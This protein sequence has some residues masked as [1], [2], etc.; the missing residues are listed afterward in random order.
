MWVHDTGLPLITS[1]FFKIFKISSRFLKLHISGFF[2]SLKL[3]LI[4]ETLLN[5]IKTL[6]R[7]YKITLNVFLNKDIL[8]LWQKKIFDRLFVSIRNFTTKYINL[9]QIPGFSMFKKNLKFQVFLRFQIKWQ[10]W[11][12][13]KNIFFYSSA[14][15]KTQYWF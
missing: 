2:F 8:C 12:Y 7:Y 14:S 5:F 3:I 10:P 1:N 9:F 6:I 4:Y 11:L 15:S 13:F